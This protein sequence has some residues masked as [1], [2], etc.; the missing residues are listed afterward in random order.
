MHA[1]SLVISFNS[2]KHEEG[3]L[4]LELHFSCLKCYPEMFPEGWIERKEKV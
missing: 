2:Y 1:L 4:V 3:I